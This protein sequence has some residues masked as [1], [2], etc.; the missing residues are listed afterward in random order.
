MTY[1]NDDAKYQQIFFVSPAVMMITDSMTGEIIDVN[2][3]AIDFYGYTYAEFKTMKIFDINTADPP[4]LL[5]KLQ[6]VDRSRTFHFKHKLK[7]GDI[8]DVEVFAGLIIIGG[9]RFINS[10]VMDIT[11]KIRAEQELKVSSERLDLLQFTYELQRKSDFIN[12]ILGGILSY[13]G[14]TITIIHELELDFSKPLFCCLVGGQAR[15]RKKTSQS[16][17]S[18]QFKK[19]MSQIIYTLS[20]CTNHLVWDN[21]DRIGIFCQERASPDNGDQSLREAVKL[22]E[23][24]NCLKPELEISMGISDLHSGVGSIEKSYREA[25]KAQAFLL[26]QEQEGEGICHFKDIG[27]FQILTS[28]YGQDYAFEFVDKMIGPLIRYDNEKGTNLRITLE[29]VL[30]SNNLKETAERLFIHYKTLVFRKQRVEKI[31]GVSLENPDTRLSLAAALK[32]YKLIN[33]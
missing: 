9:K 1:I 16:E 13:E 23:L 30:Q 7:N 22:K 5:A 18:E 24:I 8:R 17:G 19:E 32:L 10:I 21:R 31:L 3:A 4:A 25:F 33:L 27:F 20:K 29:Q 11:D 14:K 26:C 2:K 6:E 15:G 28:I 12:D